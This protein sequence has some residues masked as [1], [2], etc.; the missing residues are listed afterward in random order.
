MALHLHTSEQA[1]LLLGTAEAG[2][3]VEWKPLW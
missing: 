2:L 1:G 3:V